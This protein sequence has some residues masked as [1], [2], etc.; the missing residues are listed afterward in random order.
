MQ[1]AVTDAI[2]IGIRANGVHIE[3]RDA[4]MLFQS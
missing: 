1:S 2:A 4:A 3:V